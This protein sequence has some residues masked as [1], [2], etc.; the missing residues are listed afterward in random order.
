MDSKFTIR[1]FLVYFLT[2][3]FLLLSL[4]YQFKG[5]LFYFFD[6]NTSLIKDASA[7]YIFFLLPGLYLLGHFVQSVD[8]LVNIIM[9]RLYQQKIAPKLF[10]PFLSYRIDFQVTKAKLSVDAFWKNCSKLIINNAYEHPHYWNLMHQLFEGLTLITS[11][12]CI[13]FLYHL[14]F[15][16]F[17]LAFFLTIVFWLRAKRMAELFIKTVEDNIS[18]LPQVSS[19]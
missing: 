19:K 11:G 17:L 5:R 18:A 1:D 14:L 7:L 13:Y 9:H 2:G 8:H 12:W 16:K 3:L 10:I 15:K 4:L 6:I